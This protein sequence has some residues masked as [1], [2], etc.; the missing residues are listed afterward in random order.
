MSS[1]YR[2]YL[3]FDVL[4]KLI[5]IISEDTH[6]GKNTVGEMDGQYHYLGSEQPNLTAAIFCWQELSGRE[7]TDVELKQVLDDNKDAG[8]K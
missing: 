8:S 5:K 2:D 4:G 7:L 1:V 6:Y 3:T